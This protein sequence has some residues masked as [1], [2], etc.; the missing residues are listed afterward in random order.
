MG[1]REGGGD[2][3]MKDVEFCILLESSGPFVV[4]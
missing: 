4:L 2:Q 3:Y 1:E